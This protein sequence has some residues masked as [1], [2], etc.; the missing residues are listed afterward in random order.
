MPPLPLRIAILEC[1]TP[2]PKTR[3]KYGGYGGV[4]TS[5][6]HRAASSLTPPLPESSLQISKYDVVTAQEYPSLSSIDA[7]LISG[8]RHTSFDSDPWILKLV[9]FVKSVLAQD[10]VKIVAVCFGHQIVGRAL[11]VQVGRSDKGWEV[12]LMPA[13]L[14]EKGKEL[15]G[16]DRLNL[17]QMHKDAVCEYPTEVEPLAYTDK[18]ATHGMYIKGRLITV[19]GHPEFTGDIVRELMEARHDVGIF[20]DETFNEAIGRIK[21]DH[22]GVVVAQAFLKFMR[23]D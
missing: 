19:Q 6:L 7:V 16:L 2:A 5:L 14:T 1:D 4:F 18:C 20:D 13:E 21:E 12:S 22:D 3:E 23:E 8:S 10:R 17:F 11:G 9:E 15:F